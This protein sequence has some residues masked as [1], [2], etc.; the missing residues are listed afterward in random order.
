M[1]Q[2]L[3]YFTESEEIDFFVASEEKSLDFIHSGNEEC[4]H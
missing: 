3:R 4:R 2:M 1:K